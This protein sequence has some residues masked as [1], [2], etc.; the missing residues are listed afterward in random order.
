MTALPMAVTDELLAARAQ[1]GERAAFDDLVGRHQAMVYHLALRFCGEREAARELAQE[2]FVRA[3]R[4]LGGYDSSRPFKAWLYR[5][6][7]NTCLSA[8][9]VRRPTVSGELEVEPASGPLSDPARL[10]EGRMLAEAV[11][12]ALLDLPPAYRAAMLLRH[13]EGL[14]YRDIAEALGQ[15][16]GTVKTHLHRARELLRV[17][18]GALLEAGERHDLP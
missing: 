10:T 18:L 11:H 12:R 6:A 3:W 13:V 15:P 5:V 4:H 7:T 16:L 17:R 14:D 1:R 8:A 2:A 9:A